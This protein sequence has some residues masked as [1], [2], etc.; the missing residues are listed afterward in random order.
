MRVVFADTLYFLALINPRDQWRDVATSAEATVRESKIVTTEAVL[1]E[2]LNFT[3]GYGPNLRKAVASFAR[4]LLQDHETDVIPQ[5]RELFLRGLVLYESRPDKGYSVTD[6]ISMV[7][8]HELNI[9]E[10]LTH[11]H[12][13]MQEGFTLLLR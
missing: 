2:M 9:A 3:A 8:M 1:L 5:T 6:G 7:V 12:H 4:D 13:F 10:V 11:D